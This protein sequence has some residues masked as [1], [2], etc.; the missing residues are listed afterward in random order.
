MIRHYNITVIILA[1]AWALL[2]TLTLILTQGC[3]ETDEDPCNA[4]HGDHAMIRHYDTSIIMMALAAEEEAK[5]AITV[6]KAFR[7]A[8][9]PDPRYYIIFVSSPEQPIR[10]TT[11]ADF[12]LPGV[13]P[14]NP[15]EGY[16]GYCDREN[17]A[18]YV[19]HYGEAAP[20]LYELL[21][22]E[23]LHAAGYNHGPEMKAIEQKVM[24]IVNDLQFTM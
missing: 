24:E 18:A 21:V 16:R 17:R 15:A 13:E 4:C 23:L 19:R 3:G 10:G 2:L 5:A 8:D 6:L 1:L 9:I 14:R 11:W 20:Y 7:T 12:R 22:H